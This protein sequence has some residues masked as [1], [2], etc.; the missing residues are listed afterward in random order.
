MPPTNLPRYKNNLFKLILK[1]DK[2]IPIIADVKV[3]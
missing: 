1:I 2:N 3:A